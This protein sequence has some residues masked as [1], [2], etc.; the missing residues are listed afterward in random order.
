MKLLSLVTLASLLFIGCPSP[1]KDTPQGVPSAPPARIAE[2]GTV[3]TTVG[4]TVSVINDTSETVDVYLA[5]GSNSAVLPSS[6]GWSFCS[7]PSSLNCTFP[8]DANGGRRDLPLAG[9]YLNATLSF[10]APVGC[11]VTKAELSVNAN[12]WFD[13]V[14]ISLVD[15]FSNAVAIDIVGLSAPGQGVPADAGRVTLGPPNGPT[16]NE[17]VLGVFPVSCDGCSISLNPPC[18]VEAGSVQGCKG[19]T[20]YHPDVPCQWQGARMGGGDVVTVRLL[21]GTPLQ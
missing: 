3:G 11:G 21:P 20:Q 13:V 19:G 6:P 10:G 5:F 18:G 9:Q 15:G 16:G 2:A 1:K 12:A 7:A 14:D 4:T 8:L 17:K